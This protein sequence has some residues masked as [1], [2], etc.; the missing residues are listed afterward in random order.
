MHHH[1]RDP[2]SD[3]LISLVLEF[4]I[5]SLHYVGG[6]SGE[7]LGPQRTVGGFKT[8]LLISRVTDVLERDVTLRRALVKNTPSI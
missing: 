2:S 5:N 3:V 6:N 8:L 7:G 1:E 4:I